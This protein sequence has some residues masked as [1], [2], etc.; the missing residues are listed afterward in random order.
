MTLCESCGILIQPEPFC[1]K[2]K[3]AFQP[4]LELVRVLGIGRTGVTRGDHPAALRS[5]SD[6]WRGWQSLWVATARNAQNASMP[7]KPMQNGAVSS[8]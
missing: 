5:K 1:E 4:R 2:K 6:S 3:R 8:R 7:A